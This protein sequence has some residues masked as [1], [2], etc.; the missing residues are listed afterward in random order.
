MPLLADTIVECGRKTLTKAM[1]LANQWG[2]EQKWRG[3]KVIYGDTDSL[4]V[5]LPGRSYKEAFDFGE[6]LCKA[7]TDDN[8][9]PVQ[10]KLEKVYLGSIMQTMKRYCGMKYEFKEQKKP[11]FEAKGIETIR[12]DQCAL[13]QK[14]LKNALIT[15]FR[16]GIEG[17]KEYLFRQ[18]SQIEA[19]QIPVSDFILTG[20]VRSKY[21]GGKEGPVQAVL[22]KRMGEADP[23]RIIRHKERL[24]YVIV[25]TPGI[26]FRLKDCVLTPMELLERWDAYTIH[27]AY[28]IERHVNA[29]LNRCLGLAPHW[30]DVNAWYQSCPKPRRRIH[31]WPVRSRSRAMITTYF[32]SDVCSLC[33][34]KCQASGRDRVVVCG[35]CQKDKV[36]ASQLAMTLLNKVETSANRVAKECSRCNGCFEDVDTFAALRCS[37]EMSGSIST[38]RNS[39][40]GGPDGDALRIPLANCVCIDCPNT[41][42]RHRLREQ[43]IE[44]SATCEVLGLL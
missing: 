8:P 15:L 13:T 35:D 21:R 19:G 12:R 40:A 3:A 17:V 27:S 6:E 42:E 28:Y 5:K 22:A 10:L 31:F 36:R 14:V 32:G 1:N 38:T 43:L 44:T 23:G 33:Q 26:T 25:A 18:W 37:E 34:R 2:R 29:A 20:R 9:P 39:L 24:P 16:D 41:F 30:V 7:V 11:T 4:F